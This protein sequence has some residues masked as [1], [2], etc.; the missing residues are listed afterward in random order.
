MCMQRSNPKRRSTRPHFGRGPVYIGG[1]SGRARAR[2]RVTMDDGV[3][4]WRTTAAVTDTIGD[5]D[6]GERPNG[7]KHGV[8][9]HQKCER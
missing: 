2:A 3:N 6:G 9:G 1:G 5:T 8:H 4:D 7:G